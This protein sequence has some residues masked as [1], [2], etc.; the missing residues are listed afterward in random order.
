M[1][2]QE[3][4][5]TLEAI[6]ADLSKDAATVESPQWHDDVLK[7]TQDRLNSGQE[8]IMDWPETKRKLR[9]RSG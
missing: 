8:Q 5:Q 1:S 4:L 6:W 9:D 2:R 3:K 7:E